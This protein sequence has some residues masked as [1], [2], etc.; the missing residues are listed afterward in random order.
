MCL[1]ISRVRSLKLHNYIVKE[2]VPQ[3]FSVLIIL[4]TILVVS[5]LI[6]LSQALVAFGVSLENI[7]LPF[8]YIVVPFL[9]FNIP[10]SYFAAVMLAFSRF[11]SDGEYAAMLAGGFPLRRAAIPVMIIAVILY[12]VSCF[13][14][15]YGEAWGRKELVNFYFRK[16]QTEV[17]NLIK[18]RLQEGV[19]SEEFFGYMIYAEKIS[20]DRTRFGNIMLA[21][22]AGSK[23]RF[24]ILA[25]T[26]GISGSVLE[27]KLNLVLEKGMLHSANHETNEQSVLKFDQME[28][29]L[30]RVF[31]ERILGGDEANDDY[32]SYPPVQLYDYITT[33]EKDPAVDRITYYKARYLLHKRIATPFIIIIF[34]CFGMALGVTDPRSGRNRAYVGAIGGIIGGYVVVMAFSWF[35]EKGSI[36]A[37]FAAWIPNIIMLAFALFL[38]YQK[39][40]LPPSE[41]PIDPQHI[42]WWVRFKKRWV[43]MRRPPPVS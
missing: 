18:Y 35:A 26:G 12:V 20:A 14:S 41:S 13:C 21:P 40:R 36:S 19:F 37:P 4:S 33:I 8:L 43:L 3:F 16:T 34:A 17:D 24:T 6:R 2:V 38:M 22:A 1:K 23:D 9:S 10:I 39:N 5:Q 29:D 25:P 32:R 15:V 31:R 11:S 42:E 28:I 27:G 7:L 30:L